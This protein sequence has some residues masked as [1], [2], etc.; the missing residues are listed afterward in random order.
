M[1]GVQDSS[2]QSS[3]KATCLSDS[4]ILTDFQYVD[5]SPKVNICT[6]TVA[7]YLSDTMVHGGSL[8]SNKNL[9]N[10]Q[11]L[12][13]MSLTNSPTSLTSDKKSM[14]IVLE[15]I[16]NPVLK[17]IK[18]VSLSSRSFGVTRLMMNLMMVTTLVRIRNPILYCS[19]GTAL[20]SASKNKNNKQKKTKHMVNPTVPPSK[21]VLFKEGWLLNLLSQHLFLF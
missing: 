9:T 8:L 6:K 7:N 11:S 16:S 15:S 20:N 13:A 5:A 17:L 10:V 14:C 12:M 2:L 18:R 4:L 1:F 3:M 21:G 19:T